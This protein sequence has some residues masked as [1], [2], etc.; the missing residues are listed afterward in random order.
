MRPL[1]VV[2]LV[3]QV[4]KSAVNLVLSRRASGS[5]SAG[6]IPFTAP[7]VP[8]NGTISPDRIVSLVDVALDDIKAVK[9][10]VGGTFNDAVIA[11][12]GGAFRHY[13]LQRDALPDTSLIAVIPV[14]VRDDDDVTAANRTSAMFTTL[15]T[16]LA[17]P[18][19]RL[20]AVRQANLVGKADH[21]AVGG[22]L[23]FQAA[24]LA[25][26]N[27]TSLIARVYSAARLAD[28]HPVV[29][30]VVI[31]NVAGPPIQIYL[32][33]ARLEGVFPL[34]PVLEGP[35]LNITIVSYKDRVG[36]GLIACRTQM[37][38]VADLAA[39]VPVALT[40]LLDAARA[41][42]G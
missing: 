34:G 40:E 7:R 1:G 17:D 2:K 35:G 38:D 9:N 15:A 31:S 27:T 39:A 26:P 25:P 23:L 32:A 6:A 18:L 33:G 42:A 14:S 36:F 29:H 24:E 3:P 10:A 28:V 5:G 8:F 11:I 13:L 20:E 19:E 37:P 22:E 41:T 12:C 21:Q 16:D 30:N 4:A